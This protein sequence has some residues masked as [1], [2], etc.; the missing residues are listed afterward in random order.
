MTSEGEEAGWVEVGSP[1]IGWVT[2]WRHQCGA[3]ITED[4]WPMDR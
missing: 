4:P 2:A 3:W 1:W